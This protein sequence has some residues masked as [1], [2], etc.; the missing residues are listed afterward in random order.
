MERNKPLTQ[1]YESY[2]AEDF[3]VWQTL[4]D[5]QM[6]LLQQYASHTYLQSLE[7]IGFNAGEIP[8]FKKVNK[9]LAGLS[10]WQIT[11]APELVPQQEFFELLSRKIFPATCW[12][13]TFAELDYIEEPDMFHDVF[14]H[15]PLLADPSYAR[16]MQAF[17]ELALSWI[18]DEEMIALLSRIYWFTIEFG[19]IKENGIAKIYGAGII[20]SPGETRHSMDALTK[21]TAFDA[22][23]ALQTPYRTDVIQDQYFV[24]EN[25]QQLDQMLPQLRALLEQ[26]N[27]RIATNTT[28][29]KT[30]VYEL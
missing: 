24:I 30:I 3:L 19:L 14:G 2:T 28:A 18:E 23:Q 17:G 16:F 5:R 25:L 29:N 8:D 1:V 27:T 9:V 12:L 11:V 6:L 26:E 7:T 21:R 15:I 20:S 13:R 4:F 10:G 22:T